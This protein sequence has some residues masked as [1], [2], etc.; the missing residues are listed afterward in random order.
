MRRLAALCL[1][2][3]LPAWA[4]AESLR[5]GGVTLS[6]GDSKLAVLRACGEPALKDAYCKPV[7]VIV[8]GYPGRTTI[9]HGLPCQ[10][11]DEWLYDRG[12]GNLTVTLRFEFGRLQSIRY[13]QDGR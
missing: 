6:E 2:G 13:G 10:P 5:C 4:A 3:L 12:P 1:L 11:V 8:P 9:L 7:T